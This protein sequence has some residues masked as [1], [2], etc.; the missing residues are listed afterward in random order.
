MFKIAKKPVSAFRAKKDRLF[1]C[2]SRDQK[3]S[4]QVIRWD[5][6]HVPTSHLPPQQLGPH[7]A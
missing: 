4:A 7:G 1:L 3:V 6:A 5:T 2:G